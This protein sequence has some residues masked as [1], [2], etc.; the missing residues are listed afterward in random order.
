MTLFCELAE[1]SNKTTKS[2]AIDISWLKSTGQHHFATLFSLVTYRGKIKY[3]WQLRNGR[4]I[5]GNCVIDYLPTELFLFIKTWNG[6]AQE[7]QCRCNQKPQ[8]N[9]TSDCAAFPSSLCEAAVWVMLLCLFGQN[10]WLM[11]KSCPSALFRKSDLR[12]DQIKLRP[13]NLFYLS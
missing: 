5:S 12:R 4:V 11:S 6:S 8:G 3:L 7:K 13:H 2:R 1:I 10:Q 9:P